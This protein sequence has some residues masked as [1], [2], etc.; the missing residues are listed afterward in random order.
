[1]GGHFHCI[2]LTRLIQFTVETEIAAMNASSY[3]IRNYKASDFNN[4]V[5]FFQNEPSAN[6]ST[7]QRVSD[8]LSWP[9]SSPEEDLFIVEHGNSIIGYINIRPEL[10]IKRVLLFCR[11]N[12]A[13]RRK[14]LSSKLLECALKRSREL[15]ATAIHVDVMQ[16]NISAI[17][18]LERHGFTPARRYDEMKIDM[19]AV[20]WQQA[21]QAAIGCRNLEPGE[22]SE[23]TDIQNRSF[24]EHWGYNPNTVETMTFSINRSHTSP[25]DVVLACEE[26]NITGFCRTELI[27][28]DEGRILMMGTHP[29]HRG[30]GVGRK[31]LLAGLL[32][33]KDKGVKTTF[34][35][36]DSENEVAYALYRS[37]G[38]LPNNI[39]YTYEKT[40]E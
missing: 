32:Y 21:E 4:L 6:L 34:L 40:V 19:S 18:A 13:H 20:D 9:S 27:G 11:L 3:H 1:M 39:L 14:G 12:D 23:L 31:S 17:K 28:N 36:V 8:W 25:E 35:N 5:A 7:P 15:G 16:D 29:D 38:F 33:L 37:I 24:A 30:R 26:D 22:E 2:I 10:G